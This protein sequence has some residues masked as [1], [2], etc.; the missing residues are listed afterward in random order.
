MG[1]R[2]IGIVLL[3]TAFAG[4]GGAIYVL[5]R[6]EVA[7]ANGA[8]SLFGKAHGERCG[9]DD[10]C[11]DGL[12][13]AEGREAAFV[14]ITPEEA[15]CI[16]TDS[17]RTFGRCTLSSEGRCVVG[18]SADCAISEICRKAE[19]CSAVSHE[20]GEAS[21]ERPIPEP[22]PECTTDNLLRPPTATQGAVWVKA[23]QRLPYPVRSCRDVVKWMC[24]AAQAV[25]PE[26]AATAAALCA[27]REAR[28]AIGTGSECADPFN[29]LARSFA[30]LP[31]RGTDVTGK[32]PKRLEFARHFALARGLVY[33]FR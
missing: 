22:P 15:K 9:R 11:T 6:S 8:A 31:A 25:H 19:R 7:D 28:T 33:C 23:L 29:E 2:A 5:S 16:P 18:G 26:D 30:S 32:I 10:E 27:A 24:A 3:L 13:C 4:A 1:A 17:C 12:R 14:C 21:C 20:Q